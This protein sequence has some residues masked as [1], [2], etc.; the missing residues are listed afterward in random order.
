MIDP[1]SQ[2]LGSVRLTGGVFLEARFTA[3]WCAVSQITADDIQPFIEAPG[4]IIAYHFVIGGRLCCGLEGEPPMEIGA[5][6][7]VLMPRN[8][9]H[10]LASAPGLPPVSTH[11]LIQ[12]GEEGG[13]ARIDYG[14]GGEPTH[15]ICGFLA[16]EEVHNPLITTLP[17][18]LKL[19]IRR[20]ASRDW[21]EASVRF[22]AREFAD[23]KV[24]S[25]PVMSRLS[26][27]L[28][29]E[30]VRDYAETLDAMRS[31]WLAGLKDPQIGRALALLHGD[32][33][34]DW[35]T[36]RLAREVSMSRSAFNERFAALV[37][38][39]PIKYLTHWR[40]QLAK[41]K[42][43]DR[44][45]PIAQIAHTIGYESEVAFNRAFKREFG[46]PPARWRDGK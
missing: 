46:Q 28:F 11:D 21:V 24:G 1:L 23:G 16:T 7:V 37:G 26:E 45:Q 29:V 4:Q 39:P 6:E 20:G 10:T 8:D 35:T 38:M 33:G 42:L 18:M 9:Q 31:G 41:E 13:L 14:G 32:V 12:P 40:L 22:A 36:D 34:T 15:V 30:A 43:R 44:R 27:L 5:G 17:A 25:S 19:D 2:V 3:P